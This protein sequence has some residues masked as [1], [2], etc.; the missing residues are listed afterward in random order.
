MG[1]G[2]ENTYFAKVLHQLQNRLCDI[3][4]VTVKPVD[5][6]RPQK[7]EWN[8]KLDNFDLFFFFITFFD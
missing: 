3:S 8:V 1:M 4:V 2:G 5:K 7:L 6:H